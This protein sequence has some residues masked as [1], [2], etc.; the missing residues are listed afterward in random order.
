MFEIYRHYKGAYYLRLI[1]ALHS[2][3]L[4]N[5][6]VYRTLYDNPKSR[7]W[8]RPSEMF[9]GATDDGE[10]RFSLVGAVG[11]AFPED[12]AEL[13]SFGYDRWG[14]GAT[15][16]EFL[17][18]DRVNPDMRRGERW[19]M[20][21]SAGEKV[22]VLNVLRFARGVVGIASVATRPGKR[23]QGFASLLLRSVM[24][25]L[26]IEDSSTRFL[27]FAEI[28]PEMYERLGFRLLPEAEQYCKPAL[29]MMT[30]AAL[31]TDTERA[32]IREYF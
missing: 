26:W 12:E 29:A 1:S 20:R 24:E 21:D 15:L 6:E 31:L 5:Y 17:E 4:G 25:L 16:D 11:R 28:R 23:G 19:F 22:S 2:E 32:C 8:A 9:H 30:G 3:D 18:V 27:L 7:V 13:A 14:R 10:S